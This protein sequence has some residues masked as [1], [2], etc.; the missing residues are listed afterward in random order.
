MSAVFDYEPRIGEFQNTTMTSII[1]PQ[2]HLSA[3]SSSIA[4]EWL[5]FLRWYADSE[6]RARRLIPTLP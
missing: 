6:L 5:A 4:T 1:F 2:Q 3:L